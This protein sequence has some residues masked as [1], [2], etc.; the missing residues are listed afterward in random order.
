MLY[1]MQN[2]GQLSKADKHFTLSAYRD[3]A[4]SP[5][6]YRRPTKCLRYLWVI[7]GKGTR[8]VKN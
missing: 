2:N 3:D 6:S 5:L 4:A 8:I 1:I 7:I